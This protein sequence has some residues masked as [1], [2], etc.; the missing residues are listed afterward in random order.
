MNFLSYIIATLAGTISPFQ[1]GAS[2]QLNKD[3]ASPFW[4]AFCV[5]ASGLAAVLLAQLVLREAWP[6]QSLIAQTHW[7]AWTGGILSIALTITGLTLAHKLGS[8]LYT[9]LTLTASLLTSVILD[10]FGLMGFERHPV[11]GMRGIGAGMLA[12]GIWIIAKN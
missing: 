3:L 2:S 8:G 7:W 11:S 9:G 1:A 4:A 5:Y 6:A 12:A 10:H